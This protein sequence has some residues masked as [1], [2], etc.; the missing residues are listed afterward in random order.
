MESQDITLPSSQAVQ[1]PMPQSKHEETNADN[2]R[3]TN[4]TGT[5]ANKRRKG[6]IKANDHDDSRTKKR[7]RKDMGRNEYCRV[8]KGKRDRM[9]RAPKDEPETQLG[10]SNIDH[11]PRK[12][13]RKV[14]VLMSYCGTGYKGM[15]VNGD[16]KTIERD[17]F[18]AFVAAGAISQANS[19][20]PKKSSLTRCA[21]TDKGV[22][23]A[24][25][26]I[27]LK[28]IIEDP[29]VVEKINQN[30]PPQIRVWGLER[31]TGSFSCYQMCDSRVYEYLLPTHTLVP[32]HPQSYLGRKMEESAKENG[33]LDVLRE[34]QADVSRFWEEAEEKYIEPVVKSLDPSM[35]RSAL[36]AIFQA[37]ESDPNPEKEE[38]TTQDPPPPHQVEESSVIPEK[39]T[40]F[41]GA[42]RKLKAAYVEA[43]KSY[44]ISPTRLDRLR[45]VL[46]I[47]KGTHRFHNY[48]ISK[49]Y[50]DSSANRHIKSFTAE[51]VEADG[52][53]EWLSLK[54]HGQSFMT[55]Q[56]RKMVSMAVLVVRTGSSLDLIR[57]SFRPSSCRIPRAPG[58]GLLLERPVFNA[59]NKVAV[60]RFN[61]ETIDFV[62]Y[63]EEIQ[64]FKQKHIYDRIFQEEDRLNEF[65][66]LLAHVDNFVGNQWSHFTSPQGGP[67]QDAVTGQ[68][69]KEEGKDALENPEDSINGDTIADDAGSEIGQE[70]VVGDAS[71]RE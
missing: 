53:S 12:P 26:V 47:Y 59:Y 50:R 30:L 14:A 10:T 21:R 49:P 37:Q 6:H 61:K 1:E 36:A 4:D 51:K 45:E 31:T 67:E 44:R 34:R 13:K 63:K 68:S 23:A 28:L 40:T 22:H 2:D 27:S 55:H 9:E 5:D 43:K 7:R 57:S 58:L 25:N 3:S 17:L 71:E 15:Q 66:S 32:P 42:V 41:D 29:D 60:E 11:E 8:S 54:V 46:F 33:Q 35:Q 69:G 48:T 56:I 62:K 16:E 38:E 70:A 39:P 20:D 65:N 52:N 18:N 19:D 24:G 64:S